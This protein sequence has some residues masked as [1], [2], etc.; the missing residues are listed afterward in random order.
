LLPLVELHTELLGFGVDLL[1]DDIFQD[2]RVDGG[3]SVHEG[4]GLEGGSAVEVFV[5]LLRGGAF[6]SLTFVG[7]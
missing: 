2:G 6:T 4:G 3:F 5:D 1:F 7:G